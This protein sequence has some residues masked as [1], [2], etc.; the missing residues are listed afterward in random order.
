MIENHTGEDSKEGEDEGDQPMVH[1]A[2]LHR[3]KIE[4]KEI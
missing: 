2:R 1:Y 4:K 3:Y